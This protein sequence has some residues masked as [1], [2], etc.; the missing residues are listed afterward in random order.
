M[1][2]FQGPLGT[3]KSNALIKILN[4]YKNKKGWYIFY[5]DLSKIFSKYD[6]KSFFAAI[7]GVTLNQKTQIKKDLNTKKI[8]QALQKFINSLENLLEHDKNVVIVFDS[9]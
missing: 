4:E 3:G 6:I 5:Y 7:N 1:I 2:F 8:N 9:I